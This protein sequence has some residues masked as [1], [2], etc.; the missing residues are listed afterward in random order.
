MVGEGGGREVV[1]SERCERVGNAVSE[2][3]DVLATERVQW[4]GDR[5]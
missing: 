4:L 1:V 3:G 2:V 5:E